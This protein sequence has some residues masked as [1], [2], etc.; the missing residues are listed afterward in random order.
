M[1]DETSDY[2][3]SLNTQELERTSSDHAVACINP[4]F[5]A[6]LVSENDSGN[7]SDV[8][9]DVDGI[10]HQNRTNS[11]QA[12]ESLA[13]LSDMLDKEDGEP[14]LAGDMSV[15]NSETV[16]TNLVLESEAQDSGIVSFKATDNNTINTNSLTEELLSQEDKNDGIISNLTEQTQTNKDISKEDEPNPD[17]DVKQVRF[18][19]EVLDTDDNKFEPLK[20]NEEGRRLAKRLVDHDHTTS[21]DAV[22]NDIVD[23]IQTETRS[24]EQTDDEPGWVEEE[25]NIPNTSVNIDSVGNSE[26]NIGHEVSTY[27]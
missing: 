19:A 14:K 10:T 13:K 5:D 3:G 18:N 4:L 23:D 15:L 11:E 7:V 12:L 21:N 17:Y 27:F 22:D 2:N 20:E 24:L 9:Q 16:Y 1:D 6:N 8:N 25:I 26:L